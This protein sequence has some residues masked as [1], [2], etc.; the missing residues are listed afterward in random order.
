MMLRS[1][2]VGERLRQGSGDGS[3]GH[4]KP[5]SRSTKSAYSKVHEK[6][7]SRSTKSAYSKV[8]EK[9]CSRS[10][11]SAYSKV[12]EKPYS[13]STKVSL[14]SAVFDGAGGMIGAAAFALTARGGQFSAHGAP[15]GGFAAV[16][17][18]EAEA[19]GITLRGIGHVQ[20][21]PPELKAFAERALAEAAAGH[22]RP[23]VGRVFS[24]AEAAAAHAAHAAIT[25][26]EVVGKALLIIA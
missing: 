1:S 26:R 3:N 6:P 25:G 23:I 13:R 20:L 16:G 17:D 22:L 11:K 12:H 4:E 8:H 9:P 15:G 14:R 2:E 10:T 5:C 19:R 7:Y 21:S 18:A 24:L